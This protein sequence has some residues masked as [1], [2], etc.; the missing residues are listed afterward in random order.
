MLDQVWRKAKEYVREQVVE[1]AKATA[2]AAAAT[3]IGLEL[4][5]AEVQLTARACRSPALP[6]LAEQPSTQKL[7]FA[8]NS[9]LVD[10]STNKSGPRAREMFFRV[11]F[12]L[13]RE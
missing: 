2:D 1:E 3:R 10:P 11:R 6:C 4:R 8:S 12:F 9:M 7:T 13:K 5:L